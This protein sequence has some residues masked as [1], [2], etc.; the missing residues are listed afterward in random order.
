MQPSKEMSG[1]G[2]YLAQSVPQYLKCARE[3][4]P[5]AGHLLFIA[6]RK[7]TSRYTLHWAKFGGDRRCT[8]AS[9]AKP[10][11]AIGAS[12]APPSS[13]VSRPL[14]F[15]ALALYASDASVA[16]D[17]RRLTTVRRGLVDIFVERS[18]DASA[19]APTDVVQRLS[20]KPAHARAN[21]LSTEA[22]TVPAPASVAK[23]AA[24]LSHSPVPPVLELPDRR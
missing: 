11:D 2:S 21:P 8:V 23:S 19:A 17:R 13:H 9:V 7:A 16:T 5:K 15:T 3:N 12:V 10:T 1:G 4:P 14:E 18:M 24:R 6:N 22:T 20:G